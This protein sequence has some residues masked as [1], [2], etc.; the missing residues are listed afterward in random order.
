MVEQ[1]RY[2]MDKICWIADPPSDERSGRL[3]VLLQ[4]RS[5]G[6]YTYYLTGPPENQRVV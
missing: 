3:R 5:A 2:F 1:F 6:R 4:E